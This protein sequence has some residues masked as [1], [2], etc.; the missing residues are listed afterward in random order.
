MKVTENGLVRYRIIKWIFL[1]L[2]IL[3]SLLVNAQLNNP[4]IYFTFA[5][6]MSVLETNILG[7]RLCIDKT[8]VVW[9]IRRD[10]MYF[11]FN[12]IK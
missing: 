4:P 9:Q 3:G 11:I 6:E 8:K 12:N 10:T 1:I 7:E 2:S 5:G